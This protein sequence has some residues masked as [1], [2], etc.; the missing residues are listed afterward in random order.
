[1]PLSAVIDCGNGA[2]GTVL[3][4]LVAAMEWPNIRLQCVEV[5]GSYPN[6]EAD[7]R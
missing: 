6:H 5:D 7:P 1:M 4:D 2:G 3:P